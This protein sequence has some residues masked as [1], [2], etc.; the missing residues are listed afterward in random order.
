MLFSE[1]FF[2][3]NFSAINLHI[4]HLPKRVNRLAQASLLAACVA[5]SGCSVSSSLGSAETT[6]E[7]VFRANH[8]SNAY[9][10]KGTFPQDKQKMLDQITWMKEHPE[11]VRPQ[12]LR[13]F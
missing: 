5:A 10:I 3:A 13:G 1:S 8:G 4:D 6:D 9:T 12:G 7:I 2:G 11:I